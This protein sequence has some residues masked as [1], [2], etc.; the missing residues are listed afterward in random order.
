MASS[1]PT[2][3][4]Q[5]TAAK[6]QRWSIFIT[7]Q[8]REHG[9]TPTQFYRRIN[10][11]S[12]NQSMITHWLNAAAGA[13]PEV[14]IRVAQ[15]LELPATH[16]LREAGHEELAGYITEV[17]GNTADD[18]SALEPMIARVRRLTDGLTPEQRSALERELLDQI[19]NWYLL[20]ETKAERLRSIQGD[21]RERGAS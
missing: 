20:A 5:T 16:V 6:R 8:L 4:A 12:I 1:A 9:W 7:T 10:L 13:S 3:K 21:E 14:A 19:G 11:P 17:A 2:P 18:I 15:V